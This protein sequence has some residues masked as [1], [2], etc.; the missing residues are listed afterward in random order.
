MLKSQWAAFNT[1]LQKERFNPKMAALCGYEHVFSTGGVK[2]T[3][4]RL[5]KVM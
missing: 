5:P 2:T 3:C 1:H 4:F